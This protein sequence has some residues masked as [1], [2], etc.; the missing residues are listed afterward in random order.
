MFY[1][2]K[3]FFRA[4]LPVVH[5]ADLQTWTRILSPEGQALFLKQS[6]AEQSHALAVAKSL[7]VQAPFLSGSDYRDLISAALLHDCGKSLVTV[8]LWQRV[9]IVLIQP[10]PQG[11]RKSLEKNSVILAT[12]LTLASEHAS[13][14]SDLA[15]SHGLN[16]RVCQLIREHHAPQTSLGCLL[17]QADNQ[18]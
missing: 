12:P 2:I 7:E 4:L 16:P 10:L 13:W 9:F 14:G 11:L 8:R 3:Q 18:H 15:H 17:Q 5:S 6:R 1:R